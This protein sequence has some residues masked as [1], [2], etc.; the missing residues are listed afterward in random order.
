[1]VRAELNDA[2][3]VWD[4]LAQDES[5]EQRLAPSLFTRS[6]VEFSITIGG[7]GEIDELSGSLEAKEDGSGFRVATRLKRKESETTEP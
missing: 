7:D 2:E 5:A 4:A 1:M 6:G 3:G